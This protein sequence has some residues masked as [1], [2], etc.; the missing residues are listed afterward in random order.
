MFDCHLLA[1]VTEPSGAIAGAVVGQQRAHG[2]ALAGEELDG[3]VQEGD[4]GF[5]LLIGQHLGEGHTR[6]VVDGHV[7]SQ[8]AWMFLFAAQPAIA[9][10]ARPR[11]SVSCP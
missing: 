11:R 1:S 10:P 2:D 4:G 7:Q 3:R 6:V 8:E 5:S 9:A